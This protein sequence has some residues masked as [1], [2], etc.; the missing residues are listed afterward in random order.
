MRWWWL[1][2]FCV[3]VAAAAGAVVLNPIPERDG[4]ENA[5]WFFAMVAVGLAVC[6]LLAILTGE[7]QPGR[8]KCGRCGRVHK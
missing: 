2:L 6:G 1:G 8:C 7:P 3:Y 5:R 4:T